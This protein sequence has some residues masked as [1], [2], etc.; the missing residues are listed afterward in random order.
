MQTFAG[1]IGIGAM[2]MGMAVSLA[3]RSHP[4]RAY[5]ID[6][7]RTRLAGERGINC[8]A[9]VAE[10]AA[11][12]S[13]L[14]L[15]V[16]DSAQIRRVFSELLSVLR[17]HHVV[18]IC[19]TISPEDMNDFAQQVQATGAAFVDAPISGGPLRAEAGTM[20]MMLAAPR[21]V[22]DSI[23]P[24]LECLSAHRFVISQQP[25]DASKAKLANNLL[26]GIH[27]V[28]AGEAF[29]LIRRF[30]LDE[31]QML[32]LIR[33]SSGQSW[34]LEDRVPRALSGDLAA[35]AAARVITKD[36][37]LAIAAARR[38]GLEP[39]IAEI[40]RQQMQLTCDRGWQNRDDAAVISR[41]LG[42]QP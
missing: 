23:Q 13:T 42:D 20:S 10:L 3:R 34:M 25:G 4:V 40:A 39:A 1:I 22:V 14:F 37:T 29:A 11:V 17:S 18:A 27:L 35:R 19:S 6:A 30:G 7:E 26:A 36:L 2:G 5:D 38:L 12:C 16:V 9:K 32:E 15:V 28:A 21:P 41:L 8:L 31:A 33:V 24:T